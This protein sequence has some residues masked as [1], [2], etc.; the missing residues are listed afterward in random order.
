M[1]KLYTLTCI[2][3]SLLFGACSSDSALEKAL[4]LSGQN[5]AQLEQVLRH[6]SIRPEDSLKYKAACFLIGNM[7]G[8]GWYEGRELDRYKQWIDSVYRDQDFVF[9]AV[10]YEAFFRQ[11]G[12]VA[13]LKRRE[14]V[15]HID[16]CFLIGHI[17]STFNAIKRSPWL[18]SLSF[19]QLCEYI[20]PYRVGNEP[21]CLLSRIR[22]SLYDADIVNMLKYDDMTTDPTGLFSSHHPELYENKQEVLIRYRG[23]NVNYDLTECVTETVISNWWGRVLLFPVVTDFNPA[24]PDRNGRHAWPVMIDNSRLN[25]IARLAFETNKKGKLYRDT[26]SW[27]PHPDS[28]RKEFIPPFFRSPFHRDVTALYV[29]V[30]EVE[31]ESRIPVTNSYGYLCVFNDLQWTPVAYGEMKKG[32]CHFED[33][34]MDVVY[35]PVVYPD[36]QARAFSWPF[37]L[38]VKGEVEQLC[39]DTTCLTTL[40]LRRKYPLKYQTYLLNRKFAGAVVEA[41][42]DPDFAQPVT[43]GDFPEI[44]EEQWTTAVLKDT[45]PYRY[46]RIRSGSLYT[47]AECRLLASTGEEVKPLLTDGDRPQLY[48][49]GFDHNPLSYTY[50]DQTFSFR[51]DMGRAVALA[52]VE[53]LLCNNGNNIWPGNW[54]QLNYYDGSDWHSLGTKK[55]TGKFVEFSGI[56]DNALLWLQNLTEGKEERIFSFREGK[57]RF[58]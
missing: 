53:C 44:T 57:I 21:P 17:N 26:Y 42:D 56:P 32:L 25:G 46:W 52:E 4:R 29:P 9:K 47:I 8:H 5:R 16:S 48:Y 41:S 18:E 37:I 58:W 31:V 34:G 11:P 24:F 10:L 7:P 14:D 38:N 22:D 3:G 15:E 19:E 27:N 28:S 39:P 33:V 6:Y 49:R 36:H 55:A 1:N 45:R 51:W 43:L 13:D 20:L 23:Q 54:Y 12:A 2:L 30:R 35:L 50:P 40:Q